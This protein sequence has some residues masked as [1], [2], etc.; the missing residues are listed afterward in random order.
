MNLLKD[1]FISTTQG[2]VSLKTILTGNENYQLQYYFDEIQLAMLQLLS[3]LSTVVLQPT[4]QDLKGYLKNGLTP[5]QYEAALDKVESQWFENDCFMQSKPSEN[6]KYFPAD[7]HKVISGIESSSTENASGLFSSLND[8]SC[9]CSDCMPALNYNYQ[10]N[11]HAKAMGVGGSTG[12]KGGG[13]LTFLMAGSCLKETILMNTVCVDYFTKVSSLNEDACNDFMW[14]TPLKGSKVTNAKG[15]EVEIYQAQKIGLARGL[16]ALAY[17]FKFD[18]I[19]ESSVCDSCGHKSSYIV[20]KFHHSKY[21]GNYGSTS[22]ARELGAGW[23]PNPYTATVNLEN[24]FMGLRARDQNWNSWEDLSAMVAQAEVDKNS[25]S[26][27]PIISQYRD[28]GISKK[29]FNYLVGGNILKPKNEASIVGRVYD[30]YSMPSSLNKNLSKVTQVIDSGL[31][32]KKLLEKAFYIASKD[33]GVKFKKNII[34]SASK[35]AMF[36][37]TANAQQIIQRTLLDV[38]RKEATELRKTAV[39]E[40]KQEAQRIFMGVQRKYQHDLPLFKA[41]VKGESALYRK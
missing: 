20:K 15:K 11:V 38:E 10:T 21:N 16:F 18:V 36:R 29:P 22:E 31:E 39:I 3:S 1:D 5:E 41:L 19:E 14:V 6:T 7:I 2:K 27:A 34:V 30:L 24:G 40:L 8:F 9:V 17:H 23:W 33:D 13:T 12:I 32:Q 28:T 4:I 35:N 37:F 25:I 26:P